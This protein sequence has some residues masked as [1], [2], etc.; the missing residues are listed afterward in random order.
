MGCPDELTLDLWMAGVLPSEEAAAVD[1]H[2]RI[3]YRRSP[4][5]SYPPSEVL[6]RP[7]TLRSTPARQEYDQGTQTAQEGSRSVRRR[8]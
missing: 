8:Y 4:I 1:A 2:A 3:L 6:S 5:G 7:W